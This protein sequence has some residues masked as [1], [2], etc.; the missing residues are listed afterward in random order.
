MGKPEYRGPIILGIQGS[1]NV[2]DTQ[3]LEYRG[4]G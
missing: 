3:I 2:R 1:M 4:E